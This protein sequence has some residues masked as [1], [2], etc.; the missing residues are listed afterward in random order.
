MKD[1][2]FFAKMDEAGD[3]YIYYTSPVSKKSKYHIGTLDFTNCTY[4][5]DKNV[6]KNHSVVKEGQVKVFCWDLD[7]FKNIDL[8]YI[9]KVVPLNDVLNGKDER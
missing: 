2:T 9:T 1:T 4:I 5:S 8:S 7:D 6:S 3:A